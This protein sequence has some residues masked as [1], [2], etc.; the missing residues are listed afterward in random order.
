MEA[1]QLY[2]LV[3][4]GERSETQLQEVSG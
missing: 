3:L 4:Y 1:E 2:L